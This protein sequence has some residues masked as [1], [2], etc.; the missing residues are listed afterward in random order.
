MSNQFCRYLSNG[1]SFKLNHKN[2]LLMSPCCW[3]KNSVEVLDK[4]VFTDHQKMFG[5][6]N[7]WVPS[8]IACKQ[9][10]DA[11][12]QSLRQTASDWISDHARENEVVTI[13]INLDK[14][15]NAA[16]V[17]CGAGSST[18]W[19]KEI[20]KIN[21]QKFKILNQDSVQGHIDTIVNNVNLKN[22]KYVKFFGGEPLFTDTHFKFITHIPFPEQVTLH[23]TTNGSVYPNKE[24]LD[25]WKKFKCV[26][27]AVSLDGI[28]Q[29]FDYVRWPLPWKKVSR[30][31]KRLHSNRDLCNLLFR[32]EFTANLLNT[33]YYDRLENWIKNY[34]DINQFGDST[35]INIHPCWG[36][37]DLRKMPMAVRNL[38]LEKYEETHVIYRLV[39]NLT[40]PHSLIPWVKFVENWDT[41]RNNSW[42]KAFPDLVDAMQHGI[43]TQSVIQ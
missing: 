39:K 16:C 42:K 34:L 32:V 40:K 2:Q 36:D 43:E 17:I 1:F 38:V 6:I 30:N 20:A 31:L 11:G 28:D 10:E 4:Q 15:C 26:I 3:F 12:Q 24:T 5:S 37:W 14:Q 23:Y 41:K 25:L 19:G 29:Q 7:D 8:C 13:D 21:N 22:L 9:L 18:L 33:Y 35:E 27:F